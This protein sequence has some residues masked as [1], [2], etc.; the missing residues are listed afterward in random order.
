MCNY[1]CIIPIAFDTK[2][3]GCCIFMDMQVSRL[4]SSLTQLA[5]YYT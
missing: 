3:T 5:A 4:N 1:V 2:V